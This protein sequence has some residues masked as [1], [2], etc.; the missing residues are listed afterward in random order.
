MRGSAFLWAAGSAVLLGL[1]GSPN[2]V[3]ETMLQA[4]LCASDGAPGDA[5]GDSVAIGRDWLVVGAP[6]AGGT[7]AAYVFRRAG[8]SWVE[9]AKLTASDAAAGDRFGASVALDGGTIAV[10]AWGHDAAGEE[11]GAAYVFAWDGDAWRQ[12]ARL[13]ASDADAGD[14]FGASVSVSRGTVAVGAYANSDAGASSGAAYVFE[15]RVGAWGEQAKLTAS[16]AAKADYFGWSVSVEADRLVVGARGSDEAAWNAGGV[17]VFTRAG[18][19]WAETW[20]SAGPHVAGD[21]LGSAVSLGADGFAATAPG[22]DPGGSVSVFAC[23][24]PGWRPQGELTVPGAGEAEWFACDVAMDGQDI[25]VGAWGDGQAGPAAGAAYAFRCDGGTWSQVGKLV[26]P[27]QASGRRMGCSVAICDGCVVAGA[28]GDPDTMAGAAY[29]FAAGTRTAWRAAG[30]AGD[31]ADANNWTAGVPTGEVDVAVGAGGCA[32]VHGQAAAQGATIGAE[33]PGML[34]VGGGLVELRSL[35]IAEHGRLRVDA[36]GTVRLRGGLRVLGSGP[37]RL[38]LAEATIRFAPADAPTEPPSLELAGRDLGLDPAGWVDNAAIG[39]LVIEAGARAALLDAFDNDA[40]V[41]AGEALYVGELLLEP[42]GGLD[43][44]ERPLYFRNGGEPKRLR[45]GDADL[46]GAV[47]RADFLVLRAGFATPA[48]AGWVGGDTNADGAVDYLDY[49]ALKRS[50][51]AAARSCEV[52]A[53]PA[54][55]P[56]TLFLLAGGLL[57]LARGRGPH[58]RTHRRRRQQRSPNA[59]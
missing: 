32:E 43:V 46:N 9:H 56:G 27:G 1:L 29:V 36:N 44:G 30:A 49:V 14:S 21:K 59:P 19:D 16:D 45:P 31:W 22:R 41:G 37:D 57:L 48:D 40:D 20:S 26:A 3:A 2:A 4:A 25:A 39:T 17:Y 55:E 58:A 50:F 23:G 51:A 24:G 18:D 38:D 33:A 11:S 53:G 42:G 12:R 52:A 8:V 5:F 6:G 35:C 34:I 54:P 13:V 15:R 10:G 7:G 47:D 28:A